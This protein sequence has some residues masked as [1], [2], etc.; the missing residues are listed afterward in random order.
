MD[1]DWEL[2]LSETGAGPDDLVVRLVEVGLELY[3]T[4]IAGYRPPEL[5]PGVALEQVAVIDVVLGAG[6][7]GDRLLI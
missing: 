7:V 4:F 1:R 6:A 2:G 5:V 3:R